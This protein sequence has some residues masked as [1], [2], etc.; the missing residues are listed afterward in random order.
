M[1]WKRL[2]VAIVLCL[3]LGACDRFRS[4]ETIVSRGEAQYEKG[5]YRAALGDFKTALERDGGNL[6]ARTYLARISYHLAEFEAAQD[7]INAVVAAGMRDPQVTALKYRILLARRQ[8]EAVLKDIAAET[9]LSEAQRLLLTGQAHTE[10]G[11]FTEAAAAL[12]RALSLAPDDVAILV[13]Q[14]RLFASMGQLD[15]AADSV[16]AALKLSENDAA[17]WFMSG[18]LLV[19]TGDLAGAKT[20]LEKADDLASQQL[21][22][23]EQARLYATLVD[24]ALRSRNID[25]ATRWITDLDSRAPQTP[26]AYYLK[27]RLA[28]L[29]DNPAD[30]LA[31]LQKSTQLGNYLPARLLLANVLIAQASYGQAEEQLNKLRNEHPG[32]V[33][34]R[35][36]QAQLYLAT[37]R[38][39]AA[40]QA[41]SATEVTGGSDDAQLDWLRGQTLFASGSREAGIGLLEK[42]VASN[43]ADSARALQ[44]VRAYLALGNRDKALAVLNTL[45]AN[46]GGTQR[47]SLLVLASAMGKTPAEVRRDIDALLA[48]YPKDSILHGAAGAVYELK[49]DKQMAGELLRKAVELDAENLEARLALA[50]L[51]RQ[52][53]QYDQAE[54]QLRA[55]LGKDA[56]HVQA[57]VGLAAIAFAKG[58]RQL[59]ARELELAIGADPTVVE[60]RLQL[61][62]LAIGDKDITRAHALLEQ[63]VTASNNA[64][65]VTNAAGQLLLQA[66]Q[67]EEAQARFDQAA[68]A[69]YKP[70]RINSAQVDLALGQTAQALQK[71]EMAATDKETQLQAVALL[72]QQDVR[73]GKLDKALQ[74]IEGLRQAKAEARLVE[75]MSGD[76]YAMAGRFEPAVSSYDRAAA[77]APNQRLAIKRY[78]VRA[79]GKLPDP[80]APLNAWLARNPDDSA[81]R[82]LL[83]RHL[84]LSGNQ[85]GA[86][87]EFERVIAASTAR[88]PAI[89]NDLAWLYHQQKDNRAEA[90][91]RE[92]Y[93]AAP[94]VAAIA[95]TYGWILLTAGKS[96]EA[97]PLLEKAAAAAKTDLE[98]QYH[99]AAAQARNGQAD[100][101]KVLLREVLSSGQTFPW[102][103]EAERLL[104]SLGQ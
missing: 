83:A 42:S 73:A 71:L 92:A 66:R 4:V 9:S 24:L 70:G 56:K 97:L 38:Y 26:V 21:N 15:R 63:A 52:V 45:P 47:Q 3:N 79:E 33:E 10:M 87:R 64:P 8:Y 17:A 44:L 30:A 78:Q 5:N 85:A 49:G 23:Y 28:L 88:D 75:E 100:K 37:K 43:P 58:D 62:Q 91:A 50:T 103:S 16:N 95:D 51:Y 46:A 6:V 74:R 34:V 1:H 7:A 93:Q 12:E 54:T 32:N 29:K 96:K 101:S 25:D 98:I 68:A 31:Q 76:V 77:L 86:A 22:W 13:A 94:E 39:D 80:A 40:R 27:A 2:V 81:V 20:A 60:P 36:L 19:G 104:Q 11:Q 72:V 67:Y 59:A 84:L 102:R 35:K 90:M 48:R 65:A 61:A 14:G 55:V 99:L 18:S 57:H 53:R 89:L 69:G 82:T 41:L